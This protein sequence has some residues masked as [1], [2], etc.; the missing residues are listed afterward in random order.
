MAN[1]A[2]IDKDGHVK[3][4]IVVGNNDCVNPSVKL[5]YPTLEVGSILG[6]TIL[7]N[8]E[9]IEWEDEAMGIAF[10]KK[11]LGGKWVQTSYNG[12]IRKQYAGI[13]YTYDKINDVF[14]SPSP[15]PSWKLNKNFDW[16]AP[17]PFP[18]DGN[19]YVWSEEKKDWVLVKE[20]N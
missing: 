14:I 4:V 8:K 2:E 11:L 15:Y 16:Q 3:R 10:C 18:D 17:I 7:I 12:N 1:Y 19:L 9:V 20:K 5:A 6:K 13:G